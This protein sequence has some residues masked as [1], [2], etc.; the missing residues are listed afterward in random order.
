MGLVNERNNSHRTISKTQMSTTKT[1][2]TATSTSAA[3]GSI[4]PETLPADVG[5][6][7]ILFLKRSDYARRTV[8]NFNLKTKA[9]TK[10][11][12]V[13]LMLDA[14][15]KG[16]QDLD[17]DVPEDMQKLFAIVK[18][19][20]AAGQEEVKR[21]ADEK[22]AEEAKTAQIAKEKAEKEEKL[23]KS[24]ELQ[25]PN[26]SDLASKFDTGN[27]DRFI[28][29][30][31]VSDEELLGALK[32]G[33]KLGDFNG[34]MLGDLCVELKK[35][36]LENVVSKVAEQL[37]VPYSGLWNKAKT[38]EMIKP[39]ERQAGISFTVYQELATAKFTDDQKKQLPAV[40]A[41]VKEGKYT[42]QTIRDKVKEVQGKKPPEDV[43]PE[44]NEKK[45]FLVIDLTLDSANQVQTTVGFPKELLGGGAIIVDPV[46]KKS[47]TSMQ[48]K[49][50]NRWAA[51]SE[52]KK[53]EAPAPAE[54]K[55][56]GKK[57]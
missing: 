22:A 5:G 53:P 25:N 29:K 7:E 2:S 52:Y 43:A 1:K 34:W 38:A 37:G 40:L 10:R 31:D 49:G 47:F 33:M 51:L 12:H 6:G 42:T 48:K 23:F 19:D 50:D 4:K 17:G 32:T 44:D 18:E 8:E 16:Q 35:R 20:Y 3:N 41:E 36:G 56:K 13:V 9:D 55:K 57:K 14:L 21:I 27:M 54:D 46:T 28:A 30:S 11:D 45:V 24:I 26:L 39:D 15:D